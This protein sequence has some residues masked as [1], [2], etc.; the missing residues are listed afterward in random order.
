VWRAAAF[1]P[2]IIVA[3]LALVLW[4]RD[5]HRLASRA[6]PNGTT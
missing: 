4:S 5:A 3:V 6:L 1:V 2:Q